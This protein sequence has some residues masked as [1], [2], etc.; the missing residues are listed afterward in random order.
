MLNFQTGTD[1]ET[2]STMN[3]AELGRRELKASTGLGKLKK[4]FEISNNSG[5]K[6]GTELCRDAQYDQKSK[7]SEELSVKKMF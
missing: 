1:G 7:I 2:P 3:K 5:G 4:D 6:K